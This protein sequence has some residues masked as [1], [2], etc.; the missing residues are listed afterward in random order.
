VKPE[1]VIE[2]V[3]KIAA[4]APK[5]LLIVIDGSTT[6]K[7][8]RADLINALNNIPQNVPTKIVIASADDK[9]PVAIPLKQGLEQLASESFIGGHD[10]LKSVVRAS[11]LAGETER[12]AVLW[13]HGPQPVLNQEIYIMAPFLSAPTF[14]ELPLG[15]GDT[16]AYDFFKNHSEI[17][18]FFQVPRSSMSVKED[19]SDFFSKWKANAN[20]YE[21][22]LTQSSDKP[23]KAYVASAEEGRELLALNANQKV[24]ELV[25]ARHI[26]KS[27]RTA[28][29]YG[30]VTPVSCALVPTVNNNDTDIDDA[31]LAS[32]SNQQQSDGN[33][34]SMFANAIPGS[35]PSESS[36][37][38]GAG[39]LAPNS[40]QDMSEIQVATATLSGATNGTI[41]PQGVDATYVTGV[42][43][44]GTVRVNNL[45]NLEAL[46]NIVAN[47]WEVGLM[48]GGAIIFLNAFATESLSME[49]LGQEIEL[50]R[51]QRVAIGIGVFLLGLAFPGLVNWF[52]ASARDA[53]LFS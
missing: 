27:A 24:K 12:G 19:L 40:R 46:L 50:S 51:S 13:I 20:G 23:D 2:N 32:R 21:V 43:T 33:A 38:T 14:Y 36:G 6:V 10:N 5:N 49:V 22:S 52:V 26:R 47:L 44:A 17:G 30:L 45:A 37:A 29:A 35:V 34:L 4:P 31:A 39:T 48:I 9:V 25:L 1:Y 11:E 53:N 16:D 15:A 3:N 28:V 18:P 7:E 41:G 42:N 8:N